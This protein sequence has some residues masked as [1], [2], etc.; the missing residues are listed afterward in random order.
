MKHLHPKL[1]H[2]QENF[3]S[4]I[5]LPHNRQSHPNHQPIRINQKKQN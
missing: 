4:P 5:K 3:T 1:D 2:L